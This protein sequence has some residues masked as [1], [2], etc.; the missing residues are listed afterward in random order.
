MYTKLV[1]S[2]GIECLNPVC[3][4]DISCLIGTKGYFSAGPACLAAEEKGIYHLSLPGTDYF[5]SEEHVCD[6]MK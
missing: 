3:H 6:L 2:M 5:P 1:Q 4:K